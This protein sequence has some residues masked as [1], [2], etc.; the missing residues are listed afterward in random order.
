VED[1]AGA[2]GINDLLVRDI[3]RRQE[4]LGLA[5]IVPDHAAR[6]HGDGADAAAA[7]TQISEHLAR[8]ELHLLAQPLGNDR[9]ADKGQEIVR[10]GAQAAAIKRR[11]DASLMTDLGIVNGSIGE[12]PIDMERAAAS[13]VQHW[14]RMFEIVI[15]AAHDRALSAFRHDERERGLGHLAM[16]HGDPVFRRHVYEHAPEPVVCD[17]GHQIRCHPELGAAESRGHRVAA[18][19]D[20]VV[21]S[22]D[23][24]IAGRE[25]VG[26]EGDV[27]VALSDKE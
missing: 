12:M 4:A 15:A 1:V 22:D 18:E 24:V 11:E 26:Q 23:L 14:K 9:S 21:M 5:L 6:A 16:V 20:R 19:G 7:R 27:D 10:V 2:I 8:R 3:Q 17:R 13:Q 25:L